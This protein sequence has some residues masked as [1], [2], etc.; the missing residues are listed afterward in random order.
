VTTEAN[1]PSAFRRGLIGAAL[2]PFLAG[3][4]AGFAADA[5]NPAAAHRPRQ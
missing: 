1:P 5:V 3:V 4:S 2:L